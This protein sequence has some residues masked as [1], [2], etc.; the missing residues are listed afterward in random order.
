[1][2]IAL[3]NINNKNNERIIKGMKFLKNTSNRNYKLNDSDSLKNNSI[4][5]SNY[6]LKKNYLHFSLLLTKY[7]TINIEYIQKI[8]DNSDILR[9]DLMKTKEKFKEK[10]NELYNLKLKYNKLNKYNIDTLKILYNLVNKSGVSPNKEDMLNNLDIS[11]ILSK[12]EKESLKENHLISCFKTKLLEYRNLIEQ[13]KEEMS[14]MMKLSRYSKLAKLENDSACRSIENMN[15][16]REKDILTN[17]I[18]NMKTKINSLS[19]KCLKLKKSENKNMNNIGDLE[20][21]IQNLSSEIEIKNKIITNLT[22]KINK[23]KE[24]KKILSNKI[25]YLENEIKKIESDKKQSEIF[26]KEKGNYI[27]N[28]E[29]LNE[30]IENLKMGSEELTQY[31][32]KSKETNEKLIQKYDELKEKMNKFLLLKEDINKKMKVKEG[33]IKLIDEKIK[34]NNNKYSEIIH[35][36]NEEKISNIN[37]NIEDEI[38][39]LKSLNSLYRTKEELYKDDLDLL[40]QKILKLEEKCNLFNQ[41]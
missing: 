32:I 7:K 25:T 3:L 23:G 29:I 34:I 35:H 39:K 1:M 36:F 33:E 18:A 20:N 8:N 41:L 31:F 10:S 2:K 40:K 5:Y 12:E 16:S 30:K 22:K 13:N 24:E 9:D 37:D 26:L 11:Q 19:N 6:G 15:L 28:I 21:K 17:K 38:E 14:K 27:K 4:N